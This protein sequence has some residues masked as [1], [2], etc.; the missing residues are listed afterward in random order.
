MQTPHDRTVAELMEQL[1]ETG[2]EGMAAVFT[3]MLN[4]AM[5]IE[6]ERHVGA[7]AYE[8]SPER[9]GYANGYKPKKLDTPAGTLTVEVPKSRGGD[10]PFYPQALERGRRSSRAVMLAIAQMYIPRLPG[11]A[12]RRATS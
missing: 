11:R 8:R 6:R 7:Q 5:R 4:L 12:C 3:A 10:A 2:P 9:S 1:I